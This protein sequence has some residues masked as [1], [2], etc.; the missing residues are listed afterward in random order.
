MGNT[1]T[2]DILY[3]FAGVYLLYLAYNLSQGIGEAAGT[4]KAVQIIA[5]VVFTIAG[6]GLLI[7]VIRN[8]K[9]RVGEDLAETEEEKTEE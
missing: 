3:G 5:A 4:E 1:N 6:I 2:R 9:K 8:I 7:S